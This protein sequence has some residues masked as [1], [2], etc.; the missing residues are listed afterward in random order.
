M[1]QAYCELNVQPALDFSVYMW[2]LHGSCAC[3]YFLLKGKSSLSSAIIRGEKGREFMCSLSLL[4]QD[5][6]FIISKSSGLYAKWKKKKQELDC[7]LSW[8]H[9]LKKFKRISISLQSCVSPG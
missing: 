5:R 3:P 6:V 4:P 8:H 2:T 7:P 9:L 1:T